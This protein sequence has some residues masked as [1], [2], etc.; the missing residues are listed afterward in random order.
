MFCDIEGSTA[1]A[2]RLGDCWPEVLAAHRAILRSAVDAQG[3]IELGTEGDGL[4][5]PRAG[6]RDERAAT[7]EAVAGHQLR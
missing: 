1:L 3:G 5:D 6:A 4:A 2:R 7:F